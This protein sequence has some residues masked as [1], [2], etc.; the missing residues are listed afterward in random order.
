LHHA[1]LLRGWTVNK[2]VMIIA[3]LTALTCGGAL[4]SFFTGHDF[5]AVA[6]AIAVI[7]TLAL[8]RVFGHAEAAMVASRS[9]STAR[10]L[11]SRGVRRPTPEM[12]SA[13]QL[14]GR[15]KWQH[16]WTA[17]REAAPN[18]NVT[19]LTFQI[20]IPNLHE[21]F[22]ANWNC[23]DTDVNGNTWRATLPLSLDDQPIGKLSVVGGTSGRQALVDMQQLFDFLESLHGEIA[24]IATSDNPSI[25]VAWQTG[26]MQPA[27][28]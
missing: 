25:K 8:A 3:G 12:E 23:N 19:G 14:Q 20:A 28:N 17:L 10:K 18:Y 22:Y 26:T 5:I 15:R 13:V 11:F 9:L 6:I 24:R 2:T 16:L 4:A 7:L 1:L 27:L 21:S